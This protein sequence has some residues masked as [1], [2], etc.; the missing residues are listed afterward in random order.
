MQLVSLAVVMLMYCKA[1]II[2]Q[3]VCNDKKIFL[4]PARNINAISNAKS[5][6]LNSE[7]HSMCDAGVQCDHYCMSDSS[8]WNYF[9][10]RKV[11][12]LFPLKV[13][14]GIGEGDHVLL[15]Q[16][17]QNVRYPT[18]HILVSRPCIT[19]TMIEQL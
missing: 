4:G 8:R 12:T 2:V 6:V 1:K 18:F 13:Y 9:E 16:H 3:G 11:S 15:L 19:I 5:D 7:I 17:L 14:S 10:I